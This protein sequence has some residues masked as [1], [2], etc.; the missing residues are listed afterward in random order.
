MEPVTAQLASFVVA[1]AV[2]ATTRAKA[3]NPFVDTLGVILAGAKSEVGEPLTRYVL[4]HGGSGASPIL[5]TALTAS[6]EVAAL[7]NG[8]FGHALDFDDGIVLAPIHPSNVV[9][10]ALL[11]D[12][13]SLS[14]AKAL[15]AYV[16]GVEAAVRLAEAIGIRHYEHGWHGTSTMGLFGAV[17]A[18]AHARRLDGAATRTAFG[19]AVSMASGVQRN[20]GTMTKPLHAGWAARNAVAAVELAAAGITA[21]TDALEGR[22]GLHE[23]YGDAKAAFGPFHG[24]GSPFVIDDPGMSIKRYACCYASH[25]PMAGLLE[26][27]EEL[28]LTAANLESVHC[29]LAPGSLRALVHSRPRTGLEA[30]FS[31]EY[32]LAAGIADGSYSLWTFTD[33][34][35]ERQEVRDLLGRIHVAEEARCAEGD[36]HATTRGPS[37]RGF[38]EIH[39][40]TR[41]G[42]TGTRRIDKVPGS[43]EWELTHEELR[44]KFLDCA[45]AGGIDALSAREAFERLALLPNETRF[46]AIVELL[47]P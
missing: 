35:V 29:Y 46:A 43:P 20:F 40:R 14:G 26:L 4:S 44:E 7:V 8:S 11:A 31:L 45:S 5:G 38:V 1:G 22:S 23:V 18:L 2:P 25:R 24:L 10:S 39:A 27:R 3:I 42:A 19:I 15:D 33:E 17:A 37:R 32:A 36:P 30:K 12:A 16:I 47:R 21:A 41:A 34:A 28:G 9:L 6:A 13:G